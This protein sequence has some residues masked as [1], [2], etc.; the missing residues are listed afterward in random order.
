MRRKSCRENRCVHRFA[1][2]L[3]PEVLMKITGTM[4]RY[5]EITVVRDVLSHTAA[6]AARQMLTPGA[7]RIFHQEVGNSRL[8]SICSVSS[9]SREALVNSV[10]MLMP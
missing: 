8:R 10:P 7:F 4:I 9:V 6:A 1:D 2:L 3:F 5:Q